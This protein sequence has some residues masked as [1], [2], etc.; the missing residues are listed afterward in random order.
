MSPHYPA[1]TGDALNKSEKLAWCLRCRGE[2]EHPTEGIPAFCRTSE[3]KCPLADKGQIPS[4][5][6]RAPSTP[7][8]EW[9]AANVSVL[10][11]GNRYSGEGHHGMRRLFRNAF[12]CQ[13]K[14]S[15]VVRNAV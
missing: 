1:R 6:D 2:E 4:R 9:V 7:V 12:L 8:A 14:R 10:Q 13:M 3:R 11:L 5:A 15:I